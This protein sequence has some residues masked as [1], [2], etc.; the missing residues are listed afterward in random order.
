MLTE[1]EAGIK[2]LFISTLSRGV[3]CLD[4]A[5]QDEAISIM[6]GYFKYQKPEAW[7]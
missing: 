2:C 6:S 4:V 5:G 7:K 1:R 3:S